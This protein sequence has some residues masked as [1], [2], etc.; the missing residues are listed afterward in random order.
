[1]QYSS[2]CQTFSLGSLYYTILHYI[3]L[4]YNILLRLWGR[5]CRLMSLSALP[6]K[7]AV[8]YPEMAVL[9]FFPRGT[10]SRVKV[11]LSGESRRLG[12]W[13]PASAR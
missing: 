7:N 2:V 12:P 13:H 5:Y 4:S 10:A 1:M 8:N 6:G 11:V 9:C 3:I